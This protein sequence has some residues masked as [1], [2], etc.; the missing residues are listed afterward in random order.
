[1]EY[2]SWSDVVI[3]FNAFYMSSGIFGLWA[4]TRRDRKWDVVKVV[5]IFGIFKAA[6]RDR[7][8]A[9]IVGLVEDSLLIEL[10]NIYK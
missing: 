2:G 8:A 7:C 5:T 4:G 10:A 6:Q 9:N 1:M 3:K